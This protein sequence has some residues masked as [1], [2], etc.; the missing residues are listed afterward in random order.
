MSATV[1]SSSGIAAGRLPSVRYS[2][3]VAQIAARDERAP[4]RAASS[5][6]S[7]LRTAAWRSVSSASSGLS[8]ASKAAG[9]HPELLDASSR[10]RAP[11]RDRRRRSGRRAAS[12]GPPRRP[13]SAS[14]L[15][16]STSTAS[17]GR[18][19]SASSPAISFR[20]LQR[21]AA[22]SPISMRRADR[23]HAACVVLRVERCR[24]GSSPGARRACRPWRC[25]SSIS[26]LRW[27]RASA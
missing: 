7:G 13:G 15:R 21:A 22:L 25:R 12:R 24:A 2:P 8:C 10:T 11:A 9:D 3:A 20:S 16:A 18:P 19:L 27:A 26:V 23:R 14:P 17:A 5:V 6:S 1:S 4:A